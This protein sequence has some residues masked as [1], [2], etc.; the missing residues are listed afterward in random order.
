MK[1]FQRLTS[2]LLYILLCTFVISCSGKDDVVV[3]KPNPEPEPTPVEQNYRLEDG[4]KEIK[5]ANLDY[6]VDAIDGTTLVLSDKY[7]ET[8]LP[9]V[10]DIVLIYPNTKKLSYGFLGR[11]S[12][13]EKTGGNYNFETEQVALDEA[14]SY[15]VVDETIDFEPVSTDS[16]SNSRLAFEEIDGYNCM[17]RSISINKKIG[18]IALSVGGELTLGMRA[19]SKIHIDKNDNISEQNIQFSWY[20][21]LDVITHLEGSVEK[22]SKMEKIRIPN[23]EFKIPA[24]V[25]SLFAT[26]GLVPQFAFKADAA[27]N[28]G[29]GNHFSCENTIS[30]NNKDGKWMLDYDD[31]TGM[32]K[33]PT[34]NLLPEGLISIEGSLFGGIAISPEFR[35]FNRD[36]MKISINPALGLRSKAELSYN[37]E[38]DKSL[39]E[40]L[41]EDALTTSLALIVDAEVTAG[42]VKWLE[43]WSADLMDWD[44]WKIDERYIFPSFT[45]ESLVYDKDKIVAETQLGRNILFLTEVGLALYDVDECIQMSDFLTYRL[46]EDFTNQNRLN[47]TFENISENQKNDYSVWSYVKWGDVYI[48]C[49]QLIPQKR[50]KSMRIKEDIPESELVETY[51]FYYKNDSIEKIVFKEDYIEDPTTITYNFNYLDDG[52]VEVVGVASDEKNVYDLILNDAGFIQSCQ[53]TY[54]GPEGSDSQS[55]EFEYDE[56]GRMTC[57]KRSEGSEVWRIVYKNSDAISVSCDG[58]KT[59]SISYGNIEGPE[60]WILYEWMYGIDIDEMEVFGLIGMLGKSSKHLPT[61]NKGHDGE[62]DLH[63]NWTLDSHGYPDKLVIDEGGVDYVVGFSWE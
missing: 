41:K 38:T 11:V 61:V 44:I 31:T 48:K 63:Y 27:L 3:P 25:V 42:I 34:L 55:F 12:N 5:G 40:A 37:M 29:L 60:S 10:G 8:D 45:N 19:R 20:V 36:D 24:G 14:F 46:E 62:Y 23:F 35:L 57:M 56:T 7:P 21:C 49:K 33:E 43:G 39:Y 47:M 6:I 53:M 52:G 26:V 22:K 4:V 51:S 58:V 30:L 18:E 9:L 54:Y 16:E 1:E 28:I 50:I 2:K 17:T 15:L 13:I 32:D 59:N